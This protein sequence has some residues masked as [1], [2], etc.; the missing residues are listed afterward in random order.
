MFL[1]ILLVLPAGCRKQRNSTPEGM[2][3]AFYIYYREQNQMSL[4]PVRAEVDTGLDLVLLVSSLYEKMGDAQDNV[5]YISAIPGEPKLK[6]YS[7]SGT[8]L[9]LNFDSSYPEVNS[10]PE[11]LFRAALVKTYTQLPEVLTLEILVDDQPLE[12]SDGSVIGPMKGTDFVDVMGGGL[13]S[14]QSAAVTL[15]YASEDGKMLLKRTANVTYKNTYRLEQYIVN[16]IVQG[17]SDPSMGYSVFPAGTKV[18]SVNTKN[19]ICQVN[20]NQELLNSTLQVTPEV[21]IYSLV[22]S[23]AEVPGINA[24]QILIGGSSAVTFMDQIDLSAPLQRKPELVSE[25]V[26]N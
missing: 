6:N 22:N 10:V 3:N 1:C 8:A 23:L 17:P 2:D 25:E 16:K 19:G 15:Y 5:G 24:V 4:L 7:I 14:Y 21:L 13:N 9:T 18:I 20:F 12:R 26:Q 11:V